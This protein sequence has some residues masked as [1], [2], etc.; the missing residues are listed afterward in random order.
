MKKE[1][2]K[3]FFQV[4]FFFKKKVFEIFYKKIKKNIKKQNKI[5]KIID[6]C[7]LAW[8]QQWDLVKEKLSSPKLSFKEE[9]DFTL[10]HWVCWYG[11]VEILKILLEMREKI[12]F[13]K[14]DLNGMSPLFIACNFEEIEVLKLLLKERQLKINIQDNEGNTPFHHA[15]RLGQKNVIGQ[16]LQH[17]GVAI[18]KKNREGKTCLDLLP[19]DNFVVSLVRNYD[20]GNVIIPFF[21]LF[22]L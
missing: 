4:L 10:L 18:R 21:F 22:F 12:N 16:L 2:L 19:N 14:Q 3:I 1:R 20:T 5:N 9:D 17:G 8:T 13:N 7:F 15:C 6:I 11:N